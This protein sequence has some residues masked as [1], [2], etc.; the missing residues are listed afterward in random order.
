MRRSYEAS[1]VFLASLTL[2]GCFATPSSPPVD[3]TAK[4]DGGSFANGSGTSTGTGTGTG[5][6]TNTDPGTNTGSGTGTG[7]NTGTGSGTTTGTGTGTGGVTVNPASVAVN[8]GQTQTYTCS[9]AGSPNVGC[10]WS[11]HE[12]GGGTIEST[13]S[14]TALYTAP[15]SAGT[16]HIV[17]TSMA[18]TAATGSATVTVIAPMVGNCSNLPAA[19]TWQNVTPPVLNMSTWC[20][21]FN[22]GCPAP[23]VMA[24]GLLGTYGTQDFALDPVNEGTIYLGTSSMGMFKST[25]CGS[26][27]TQI[28]MGTGGDLVSAGRNWSMVMDPTNPQVLYTVAGY[29][30]G[31][32]FKSTDRGNS[33]TQMFTQNVFDA[34]GASPCTPT[35]D[36]ALCGGGGGFVEKITMDPTNSSHLLASFHSSCAGTT[37]LPGT[38]VSSMGDWG[39]LAETTDAGMTWSLTTNGIGW[40]GGD[41]PGQTMIDSKTWFY[42]TNSCTGIFR[43]TTGGVSPDGTSPAWTQ[44]YSGCVNGSVYAAS[45][46]VFFFGGSGG[47]FTSLDGINWMNESLVPSSTSIN[48]STPMLDDGTTFYVGGNQGY[49]SGP[50]AANG[51][52]SLTMISSTP[53][54]SV[55]TQL[56]EEAPPAFMHYDSVKHIIYTS[57]MDGGFW[58]YVTQ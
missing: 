7:T 6:G 43:T 38:P 15:S 39:C 19:G 13:G 24:N 17:A 54:T 30:Q 35:G 36:P 45:N 48:G 52:L 29:G 49:Y 55:T 21:P 14:T 37:P 16:F 44:V 41:G 46:S 53:V 33:W 8:V 18:S 28:A 32:V 1:W 3:A 40:E 23:Q 2:A 22:T 27:W 11:L 20:S 31:G 10:T 42:A 12:P 57:N 56:P 34:T 47:V 50:L 5:S 58:R 4:T 26:T 9:V 51:S 25:D